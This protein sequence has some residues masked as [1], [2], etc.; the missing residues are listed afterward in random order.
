MFYGNFEGDRKDR[1]RDALETFRAVFSKVW[2][3]DNLI[4]LT[5]NQSFLWEERFRAAMIANA[6]NE[7]EKSLVWRVHTLCWAGRHALSRRGDFV[8][9]GVYRGFCFGV[10]TH[11]LDFANVDK[12]LYLYDTFEGIPDA[13]NSEN[14]SNAVYEQ[15]PDLFERVT[16]R[17]SGYPNVRVVQGIVPDTFQAEV[18]EAIALLHLD[19]NSARS[20][21]EA[22]EV[23]YDRVVSGGIIIFD[24]FGWTGYV[25]QT[26]AEIDFMKRRG[27]SIL[28]LPT[29]QGMVIK[30]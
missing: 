21:I 12:T 16:S 29:G 22:L 10:L 23:L 27:V 24:D 2:A 7:Q 1:L 4:A 30:P 17:F 18:P 26:V 6:T 13:Y 5:R 3:G 8:E 20:E 9:C 11:Y 28:E 19:M 14:R 25:K 15:E